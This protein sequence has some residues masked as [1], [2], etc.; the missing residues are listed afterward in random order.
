VPPGT[1]IF[2]WVT[3]AQGLFQYYRFLVAVLMLLLGGFL[4]VVGSWLPGVPGMALAAV[5]DMNVT[6]S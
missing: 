5:P 1:S 4:A 6:A 3:P 2:G